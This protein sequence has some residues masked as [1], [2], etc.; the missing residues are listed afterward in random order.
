MSKTWSED[1]PGGSLPKY[2]WADQLGKSNYN[3][4]STM[5][6]YDAS[7]L[8]IR[9]I[10]L[11]YTLPKAW[12]NK[13]KLQNVEVSVTGQNL[14]YITECDMVATPETLSGIAGSGYAL[15]RTLLFG[16]SVTL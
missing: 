5:F 14:G 11:S 10:S 15:P 12:V 4:T 7:Y 6:C 9:E 8:S 1:N 13:A 2:Y 16:I 3:R